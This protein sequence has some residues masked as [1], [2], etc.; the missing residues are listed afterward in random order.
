MHGFHLFIFHLGWHNFLQGPKR[1]LWKWIELLEN[2]S[3]DKNPNPKPENYH[4][5]DFSDYDDTW[6]C[7][8]EEGN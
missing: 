1:M 3:I 8:L 5:E 2:G 4:I 7:Q 6:D